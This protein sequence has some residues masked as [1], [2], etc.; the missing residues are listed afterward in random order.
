MANYEFDFYEN[1]FSQKESA[2]FLKALYQEIQWKQKSILI[3]GKSIL[4]PRL[5]AWYGDP[6]AIYTYSGVSMAPHPWIPTLTQIKSRVENAC[7]AQFNSVL[8]NLYRNQRDSM[9][10]HSDDE[11][12][13]GAQPVIA[14]ASFGETRRFVMKHRTQRN[15]SSKTYWLNSGSLL[16]MRG[17]TQKFWKHGVP[18]E[19]GVCG[20][21]INLTFRTIL[22]RA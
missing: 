1:F 22:K 12:E 19:S 3:F 13:L 10:M 17:D 14:S 8:L 15:R 9:G 7:A 18:K 21:R 16:I 5:T 2:V 4:E 20:P 6:S 11:K